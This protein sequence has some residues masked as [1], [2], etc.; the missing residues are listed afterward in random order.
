[1]TAWLNYAA[2]AVTEMHSNALGPLDS[3]AHPLA[4]GSY[5]G[6]FFRDDRKVG[7]FA[8]T[9][10]TDGAGDQIEIDFAA[11][12]REPPE[13]PFTSGA[14]KGQHPYVV[15]HT[16]GERSGYH[17]VL[18]PQTKGGRGYDSRRLEAGDCYITTPIRPGRYQA[19][20]GKGRASAMLIVVPAKPGDKPR[21]SA[22]GAMVRV[23]GGRVLPA[24]AELVSGDGAVFEIKEDG[25]SISLA[26]DPD[27][28]KPQT[29]RKV[30]VRIHGRAIRAGAG[31]AGIA[32]R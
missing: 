5:L 3:L 14:A 16:S 30:G 1:M 13:D 10:V 24:T 12:E 21:P 6:A 22:A 26:R 15:F 20:A 28:A 7:S 27:K 17:V 19:S 11:L 2:L 29:R 31:R 32:G 8:I 9:I 4:P 23:I 18:I 25:T